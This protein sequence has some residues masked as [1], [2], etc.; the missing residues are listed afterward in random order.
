MLSERSE[1][2]LSRIAFSRITGLLLSL[3]PCNRSRK[4][5]I[6]ACPDNVVNIMYPGDF[7]MI[8][9]D[10]F[11]AKHEFRNIYCIFLLYAI[12]TLLISAV[13]LLLY[14]HRF[15][16]SHFRLVPHRNIYPTMNVTI[17]RMTESLMTEGPGRKEVL[18]MADEPPV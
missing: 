3:M 4:H 14:L 12:L 18:C 10:I 7:R 13:F 8:Y 2:F 1:F 5:P 15:K 16:A 17:D 6:P 9:Q 11:P